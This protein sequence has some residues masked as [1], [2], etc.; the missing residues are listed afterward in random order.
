MLVPRVGPL[1]PETGDGFH[2]GCL[3]GVVRAN[4]EHAQRKEQELEAREELPGSSEGTLGMGETALG[5][6]HSAV[7]TTNSLLRQSCRNALF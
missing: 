7:A 3:H 5:C 4:T 2:C 1:L 6:S